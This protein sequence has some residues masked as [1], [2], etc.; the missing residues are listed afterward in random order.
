[1]NKKRIGWMTIFF[2]A[3][4]LS[5]CSFGHTANENDISGNSQ[6]LAQVEVYSATEHTLIKT[7][8]D[9][10]ALVSFNES[11]NFLEDMFYEDEDNI[12][13]Q[14]SYLSEMEKYEPE[15]TFI[16]YKKSVADN[17]N[18]DFEALFEI[19]TYKDTNM[20]MMKVSPDSVKNMKVPSEYLTDYY[21]V[22]DEAM[23]YL[24]SLCTTE[25]E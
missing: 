21:E 14:E 25:G 3:V 24:T 18:E 9:K 17:S 19:T 8:N 4:V 5:G 15:Y 22:S 7:I 1:M 11:T 23:D 6:Q 10:E 2:V 20:I 13:Q 16:T 12:N